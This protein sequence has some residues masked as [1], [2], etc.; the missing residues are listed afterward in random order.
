MQKRAHL[1]NKF[2]SSFTEHSRL[3]KPLCIWK[4][5]NVKLLTDKKMIFKVTLQ[6]YLVENNLKLLYI[7]LRFSLDGVIRISDY[8][9]H[10][11][12]FLSIVGL[13]CCFYS[14]ERNLLRGCVWFGSFRRAITWNTNLTRMSRF[15]CICSIVECVLK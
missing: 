10:L 3:K 7:Q 14:A 13:C 8:F 9:T 6:I 1:I 2:N 12:S 15:N 11:V 4:Y 5:D